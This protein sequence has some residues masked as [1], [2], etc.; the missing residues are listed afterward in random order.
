MC[1]GKLKEKNQ[2]SFDKKQFDDVHKEIHKALSWTQKSKTCSRNTLRVLQIAF[3]NWRL[4]VT[5]L[6]EKA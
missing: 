6:W 1:Y 3:S 2:P 5:A 4:N